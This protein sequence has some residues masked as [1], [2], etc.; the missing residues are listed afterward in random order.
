MTKRRL[1][2]CL[3]MVR[4]APADPFDDENPAADP[5]GDPPVDA[6]S[7]RAAR[8]AAPSSAPNNPLLEQ[9]FPQWAR[10]PKEPAV[11]ADAGFEA[12]FFAGAGLALC[13]EPSWLENIEL[14]A[15]KAI[16]RENVGQ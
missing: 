13:Q 1:G 8:L 11:D 3:H 4:F 15:K 6:P 5:R 2:L 7:R 10:P 12:A 9:I 14:C 16:K